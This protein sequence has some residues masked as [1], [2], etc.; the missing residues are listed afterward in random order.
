MPEN[1]EIEELK[2]ELRKLNPQ[3][4]IK[5]LKDLQEKRKA[6]IVGIDELIKNSEKEL[7][8]ETVAE[9]ISPQHLEV[10]IKKMFEEESAQLEGTVKKEAP[11]GAKGGDYL[12]LKQAHSYY[13]ALQ[14]IAYASMTGTLTDSHL[15]VIDQIGE[16][17][18]KTKY[19]S[20]SQDAVNL[21]VASKATLY[22]I[23][24]YAGLEDESRSY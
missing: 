11:Q 6:E 14:D 13:S 2:K 9:K 7:R 15:D 10:N 12:S 20:A 19:H 17:L 18:D 3:D 16:K 24:K 4:K 1:E 21:L 8:A 23:R 22:K 5:K